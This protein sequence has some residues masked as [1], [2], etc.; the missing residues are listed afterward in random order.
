VEFLNFQQQV[1]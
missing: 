1:S